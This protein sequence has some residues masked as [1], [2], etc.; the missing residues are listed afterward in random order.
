MTVDEVLGISEV[1]E[2]ETSGSSQFE[3]VALADAHAVVEQEDTVQ[4]LSLEQDLSQYSTY[5]IAKQEIIS[6]DN[7]QWAKIQFGNNRGDQVLLLTHK[8][9]QGC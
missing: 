5:S 2:A 3:T 9:I 8:D 6:L 4:S 1:L 7:R